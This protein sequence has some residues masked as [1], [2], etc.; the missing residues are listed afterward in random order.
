MKVLK[1][2]V[3]VLVA[4]IV[5]GCVYDYGVGGETKLEKSL[6]VIEGDIVAGGISEVK[7]S[8]TANIIYHPSTW[9]DEASTKVE[10][11]YPFD[12]VCQVWVESSAG[13]VWPGRDSFYVWKFDEMGS[14]RQFR[15]MYVIDTRDLPLDG[16]YRLCVSYPDRGE[17]H[18]HF[19]RVQR[20]QDIDS[21]DFSFKPDTSSIDIVINSSGSEGDAPYYRWKYEEWW[22]NEPPLMPNVKYKGRLDTLSRKEKDSLAK[23]FDRF[24]STEILI[25]N[26]EKLS[27][28][29]V[30]GKVIN[31]LY[32]EQR[33]VNA[34]YCITVYQYPLDKEGYDYYEAMR[35]NADEMG[36]L[37]SPYPSEMTGNIV[38][39]TYP[40]ELVV[41]YVNVCT[42]AKERRFLD[43]EALK[44]FNRRKCLDFTTINLDEKKVTWGDAYYELDMRPYDC[45][46]KL[47]PYEPPVEPGQPPK[48]DYLTVRDCDVSY[49]GTADCHQVLNCYS[50]PDFWPR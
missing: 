37:F 49:W 19:K 18:S 2:A 29:M 23:C 25:E 34:L 9:G 44:L 40:E 3:I 35:V 1:C 46:K 47:V 13:E 7:I 41:G 28:N 26:T 42:V 43:G 48:I 22:E 20:A 15:R 39:E 31:T 50:K 21:F 30:R 14:Y 6:V 33:K 10:D 8:T 32:R 27:G 45:E 36:G 24:A 12:E 16:E 5:A 17:Y 11:M 4:A 38:C